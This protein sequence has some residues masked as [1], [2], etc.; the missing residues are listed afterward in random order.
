MNRSASTDAPIINTTK[1]PRLL[2]GAFCCSHSNEFY[3]NNIA[4]LVSLKISPF[5]D[6]AVS[7]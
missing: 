6:V 2:D 4:F 3:F 5:S 7:R 1:K